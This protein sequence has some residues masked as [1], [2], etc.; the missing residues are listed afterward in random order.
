MPANRKDENMNNNQPYFHPK[1]ENYPLD[2]E[3][4]FNLNNTIKLFIGDKFWLEKYI[5]K[6][7]IRKKAVGKFWFDKYVIKNIY[8][9]GVIML[10]KTVIKLTLLFL[11][12]TVGLQAGETKVAGEIWNRYMVYRKDNKTTL[13]QFSFDRGYLTLEPK[14]SDK[15][16]GRFTLDFFSSDK[17]N[18]GA[19]IKVKYGFLQFAEPI[20]IKE[21]NLEIG[22]VKNYFG[23]VYDW[24]YPV[25]EK[26][27]EDKE[28][29]AASVDYGIAFT[30]YLPKG[31]GEYAV[32]LYNGEGY[33]KTQSK[34]NTQFAPLFNL[35]LTPI[36]GITLGGSIIVDK[37]GVTGLV[38]Q[39]TTTSRAE[40]LFKNVYDK[41]RVI[42]GITKLAFGPVEIWGEY[43]T[44]YYDSTITKK[45]SRPN[46]P[47]TITTTTYIYKSKGFSL[48][49]I[50]SLNQLTGLDVELVF[51]YD[52]WDSNT[53]VKDYKSAFSTMVIGGNYNILRGLSADP[54]L[55]LQINW[56]R[57][58]F[59]KED[60]SIPDVK[61]PEDQ[62]GVQL[63]WKYS[64]TILN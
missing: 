55:T 62:I 29:V 3:I 39:T 26:A 63:K 40:S 49:P 22:L 5:L 60:P 42:A 24:A 61:K 47:D 34:V 10:K 6:N 27:I 51:R 50:F 15:I 56:Q 4:K 18:D 25:I 36:A 45:V 7:Y 41:R 37:P 17:Y 31:F 52:F 19:G 57:K 21:S 38:R 12:W 28:K 46:I 58:T 64:S 54:V 16:K 43:L 23:L 13:N 53:D 2:K 11:T 9:K 1:P 32:G 14:L 35:R 59:K 48:T 44:N 20:P 8:Q 33:T 30:G